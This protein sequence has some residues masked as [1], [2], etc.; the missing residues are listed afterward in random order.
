M[1]FVV[2]G[3]QSNTEINFFTGL[4][5]H[6]IRNPLK[7]YPME[8][9][10]KSESRKKEIIGRLKNILQEHINEIDDFTFFFIGDGDK[11][12][13]FQSMEKTKD[14]IIEYLIEKHNISKKKILNKILKDIPHKFED[15]YR[16][17]CKFFSPVPKKGSQKKL[18]NQFAK[19]ANWFTKE[20][21]LNYSKIV[22]DMKRT[23]N[24]HIEIIKEIMKNKEIQI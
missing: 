13:D 21:I 15:S 12:D 22:D 14:I 10:R 9:A 19:K 8:K 1:I 16:K 2:E 4:S 7:I 5:C 17:I 18:F 3:G 24:P 11:K 20:G 23:K 6:F